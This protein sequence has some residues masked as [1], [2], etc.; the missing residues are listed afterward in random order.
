M[1]YW[2]QYNVYCNY[3]Y[4]DF[5]FILEYL[6]NNIYHAFY[7]LK[8]LNAILLNLINILLKMPQ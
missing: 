8:K 1:Q 4:H 2:V 5:V 3:N 6:Q 7:S